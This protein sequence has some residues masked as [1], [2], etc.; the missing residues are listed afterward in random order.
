VGIIANNRWEWATIAA[1]TYSLNATIVPLY[2]AQLPA[3]WTYIL[4][5]AGCTSLFCANQDIFDRVHVEVLPSTPLVKSVL[6]LDAAEG[7]PHAFSTH[8]ASAT[9]GSPIIVPTENDLADLIYTSGTTGK[10]KGVEL[11]HLNLTS[12]V[13]SAVRSMV[14]DPSDFVRQNDRSLAFL[15]W[16]HSYGQTCELWSGM[17]HGASMGICRGIPSILEDLQLV[18]PTVLFSVPTLYKRI[19]DGVHNLVETSSPLR[20]KLMKKAL[21]LGRQNADYQHGK[22][23][24]LGLLEGLQY[25]ALDSVVLS[26]IRDRFGGRLRHGFVAGAATPLEVLHFMDSLSI[27]VCEGYG[28][29]ETSPII[30]LNTPEHRMVGSVGRAIGGVTVYVIGEDGKPVGPGLEGEICCIGPNVMRSYYR[31]QA[32]TDEVISVAPDGVSRM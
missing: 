15:P 2:E 7:E 14:E 17:S 1:A 32:A 30:C 18:K 25:K 27:P 6:C 3:D 26:K 11:T 13:K 10:P 4:N 12:N 21:Y 28:L 8:M 29:T 31:N 16:A 23:G 5:D 24:P 19:Y 9:E 20:K 22:R